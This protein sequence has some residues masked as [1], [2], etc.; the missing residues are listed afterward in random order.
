ME[1]NGKRGQGVEPQARPYGKNPTLGCGGQKGLVAV[2]LLR[3]EGLPTSWLGGR[4][5]LTSSP[6][7]REILF[8][9]FPVSL[10]I[11]EES[12]QASQLL[13]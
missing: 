10:E 6:N 1:E 7:Q 12:L 4:L 9:F 2:F 3:Q 11:K 5:N 8:F 13:F